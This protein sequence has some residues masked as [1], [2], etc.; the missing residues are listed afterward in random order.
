MRDGSTRMFKPMFGFLRKLP[1]RSLQNTGSSSPLFSKALFV[2]EMKWSQ[3]RGKN[4]KKIFQTQDL[5][6][7]GR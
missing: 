3:L 7:E 1:L 6:E 4:L 2:I 5:K